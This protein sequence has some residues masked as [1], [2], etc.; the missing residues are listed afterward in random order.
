MAAF[1]YT[2]WADIKWKD[3]RVTSQFID[4]DAARG[5]LQV[6]PEDDKLQNPEF[7][8]HIKDHPAEHLYFKHHIK[9]MPRE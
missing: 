7:R 2:G 4:F 8:G 5:I 9:M 3:G 6:W 1:D